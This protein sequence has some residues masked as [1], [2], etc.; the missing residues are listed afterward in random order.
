MD[1]GSTAC[2]NRAYDETF[3]VTFS[4]DQLRVRRFMQAGHADQVAYL[5]GRSSKVFKSFIGHGYYERSD[6]PMVCKVPLNIT[7]ATRP[8]SRKK[9]TLAINLGDFSGTDSN[10]DYDD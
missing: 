8:K 3:N 5:L 1:G 4:G 7:R 9:K 10:T 2:F 6:D